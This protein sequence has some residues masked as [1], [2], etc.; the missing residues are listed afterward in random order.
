MTSNARMA[1]GLWCRIGDQFCQ[2][3][4]LNEDFRG[5]RERKWTALNPRNCVGNT[6]MIGARFVPEP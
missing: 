6:Q 3:S 2:I 1:I 5:P 4:G